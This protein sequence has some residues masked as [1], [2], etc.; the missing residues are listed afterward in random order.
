[1]LG[2]GAAQ[3]GSICWRLGRRPVGVNGNCCS[4]P[5]L[6]GS[7]GEGTPSCFSLNPPRAFS[8]FYFHVPK[9]LRR[10]PGSMR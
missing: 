5:A 4:L 10:F 6:R 9:R 7:F 3:L 8:L 1:M 2:R